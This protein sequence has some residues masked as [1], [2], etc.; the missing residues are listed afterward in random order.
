MSR[1]NKRVS[2][3]SKKIRDRLAEAR[4]EHEYLVGWNN[5]KEEH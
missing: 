3:I 2:Y 1:I 4:I 5:V